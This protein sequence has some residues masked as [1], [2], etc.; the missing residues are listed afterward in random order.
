MKIIV[1]KLSLVLILVMIFSFSNFSLLQTFA[2]DAMLEVEYDNCIASK[3]GDS[4]DEMWYALIKGSYC[5]HLSTEETTIKYYFAPIAANGY[6]WTTDVSS[7]VAEEIKDAYAN[8]MKKWNNVYFYSYNTCGEVIKC[9][10]INV[11]EAE[12]EDECNLIIYPGTSVSS[13]ASTYDSGNKEEIETGEVNHTHFSKWRM[14][15]YVNRFYENGSYTAGEVAVIR[16]RTGA[17]ELGHV[18][19]LKDLDVND[20]NNLCNSNANEAHHYEL[21]MGYGEPKENRSLNITYKDIAGVAIT[22]GFHTDSDHKWL[23]RGLQSSGEYKLICSI[24]NG[25]RY[26]S[27]LADYDYYS[28][29]ACGNNHNLSDGNMMAVASYGTQDYYKCKYCRYVAPFPEIVTQDY[30]KTYYSESLHKC[31]NTVLGLEYTFYEKHNAIDNECLE[32]GAHMHSYTDHYEQYSNSQ[33]KA[34]CECGTSTLQSHSREYYMY[35]SLQH[36]IKCHCGYVDYESH[37]CAVSAQVKMCLRCGQM[38][39][40]GGILLDSVDEVVYLTDSGSYLRPDG[41][42]MLSDSD[43]E[44]YLAGG[45]DIN[46]LIIQATNPAV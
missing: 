39:G 6:T 4:I 7:D 29:G 40:S 16:E 33:H 42:V 12:N 15:L 25:V 30:S 9:K 8:S 5:Y 24:C 27:N 37:V 20:A 13:I 41:I 10:I 28:Y 23:N 19:G 43:V 2:H 34:Y 22:R 36:K 18:L 35:N 32:C 17:H 38:A 45:L 44:L 14:T 31:V 46:V 26:V 3:T 1:K 11:V 21:L